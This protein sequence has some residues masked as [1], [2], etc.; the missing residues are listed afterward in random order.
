MMKYNPLLM[1][2]GLRSVVVSL[3]FFAM[4]NGALA[5]ERERFKGKW[6]A[7]TDF[8]GSE[9]EITLEF[10]GSS[11]KFEIGGFIFGKAQAVL[12]EHDGFKFLLFKDLEAGE[13]QDTLNP[14]EAE[15]KNVYS[16]GYRTLT[17]ASNFESTA[18]EDPKLVVYKK[19]E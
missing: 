17:L 14:V 5:D 9:T 13:S 10:S 4:L 12:S 1:M 11:V 2:K 19:V 7:T 16:F 8:Q 18:T 15:Y 3:M 6:K